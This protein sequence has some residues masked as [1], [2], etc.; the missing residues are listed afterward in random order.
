MVVFI[1][2]TTGSFNAGD[3]LTIISAT[4]FALHIVYLDRVT[5]DMKPASVAFVAMMT[6]SFLT[7]MA[8]MILEKPFLHSHP[9]L[10]I[11]MIYLVIPATVLVTFLQVRFQ[12]Q[13]TPVR[14]AILFGMEPVFAAVFA[15][16]I[17]GEIPHQGE[18]VGGIIIVSGV[19]ISEVGSS[20]KIFSR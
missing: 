11:S 14:A 7:L 9:D 4:G 2:P 8:S 3:F 17:T 18:I 13:T 5:P 6:T 15:F 16:F 20:L 1:R 19:L 10:W 12:P